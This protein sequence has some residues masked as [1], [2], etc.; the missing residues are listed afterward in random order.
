MSKRNENI[1]KRLS[2]QRGVSL[3]EVLVTLAVIGFGILGIIYM[4][5]EFSSQSAANKARLEA[6]ALAESRIEQLRDST[7]IDP[8]STCF[9]TNATDYDR[10]LCQL[11]VAASESDPM[12]SGINADFTRQTSVD[13]NQVTV[14]VTWDDRTGALQQIEMQT[15]VAWN[16]PSSAA[17]P[18][19]PEGSNN[20]G[21]PI[22]PPTGEALQG[23]GK[24]ADLENPTEVG[25]DNFD[26]TKYY[27]DGENLYLVDGED[28]V[29]TLEAVCTGDSAVICK[30]FVTISGR[31]YI[32]TATK[33]IGPGAVAIKS[34]DTTYCTRYYDDGTRVTNE[35]GV[36]DTPDSNVTDNDDYIFY[37]YTCYAS[38]GWYGNIGVIL[39]GGN[40]QTDKVCQ[41]DPNAT[42]A[43]AQPVIAA[44]RIYR[45]MYYEV[46]SG[47]ASDKKEVDSEPLYWSIGMDEGIDLGINGIDKVPHDFVVSSM[48]VSDTTGDKCTSTLVMLRNPDSK[49]PADPSSLL[50]SRFAGMATD[51][52]CLNPHVDLD[53]TYTGSDG[54]PVNFFGASCGTTPQDGDLCID[55]TCP[56]NPSVDI[57]NVLKIQ[58]TNVP[59]VSTSDGPG[60]CFPDGNAYV[61]YGYDRGGDGWTGYLQSDIVYATTACDYDRYYYDNLEDTDSDIDDV[62][63]FVCEV[64]SDPQS[65]PVSS[66]VVRG[67]ITLLSN[68]SL[69]G[70]SLKLKQFKLGTDGNPLKD[71][72][73][74]PV[75][76]PVPDPEDPA[77]EIPN[78]VEGNCLINGTQTNYSCVSGNLYDLDLTTAGTYWTIELTAEVGGY[79]C[80]DGDGDGVI[81]IVENIDPDDDGT[82]D[83]FGVYSQSI[84]AAQNSNK[85]P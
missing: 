59:I 48:A 27:T 12:I 9:A 84:I 25:A 6:V 8:A 75:P 24:L 3:T 41:G 29:L 74:N 18:D 4:Q 73:G 81:T 46:D 71:D 43:T 21:Q 32:D 49:D 30:D 35:D 77:G 5:G 66:A 11:S 42:D 16:N 40:Q 47:T 79:V 57:I 13:G 28:I 61:C 55:Q 20:S 82:I 7:T 1:S 62:R 58:A 38:Y 19:D 63:D 15:A 51:F 70:V 39:E 85:C 50:G 52:Y 60:N 64:S 83:S 10:F 45:G 72:D 67:P 36:S 54:S 34:S 14:L 22:T 37:D 26:G 23:E 65:D 68:T 44:R 2:D 17:L 33:N 53:V 78:V 31:V 76:F 56:F 69:A 80:N